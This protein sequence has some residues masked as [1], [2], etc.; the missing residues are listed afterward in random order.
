MITQ[1]INYTLF[2]IGFSPKKFLMTS[3]AVDVADDGWCS[4]EGGSICNTEKDNCLLKT[5]FIM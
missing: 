4:G 3:K 2:Y 5:S 1:I